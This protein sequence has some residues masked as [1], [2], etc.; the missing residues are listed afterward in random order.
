MLESNAFL[1]EQNTNLKKMDFFLHILKDT[2][3]RN[4][5]STFHRKILK[6]AH[7]Q[8]R[9]R[10]PAGRRGASSGPSARLDNSC[11]TLHG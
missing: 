3:F 8:S 11:A 6:F 2:Y 9:P 7:S 4:L 1:R 5:A 10:K